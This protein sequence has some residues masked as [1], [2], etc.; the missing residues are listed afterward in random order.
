[1]NRTLVEK[2][3]SMVY[4]SKLSTEM[5]G[6]AVMAATYLT[7]R[8]FTS[9]LEDETPA[10]LWYGEKPN[11][12]NLRVFGCRCYVH[13]PKCKRGKMEPKSYPH[14]MVGYSGNGYRLWD[15][16]QRKIVLSR[17]VIFDEE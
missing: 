1:M 14:I 10:E 2:A 15:A 12:S 3:R 6:E 5:W 7:N 16:E 13:V 9:V 11:V 8:S 4:E 17:D